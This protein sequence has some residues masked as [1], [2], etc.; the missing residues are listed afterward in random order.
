MLRGKLYVCRIFKV[1][2]VFKV[3]KD[4]FLNWVIHRSKEL[5]ESNIVELADNRYRRYI[6]KIIS[7][8]QIRNI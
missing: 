4:L 8:L 7:R 2:K 1:F 3:I 6:W 5:V